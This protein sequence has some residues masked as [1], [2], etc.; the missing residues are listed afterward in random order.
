MK[1]SDRQNQILELIQTGACSSVKELCSVIYASPATIRRD[2]HAM[3]EEGLIRLLYGNIIPLTE[4]PTELPL[5]FRESQAKESRRL[6]AR[7]AAE[8][9][10]PGS[11]VLLDGSAS[12]AYM[13]DH[14]SP[15]LGITV[16]TNCIKT[17][18]KLS[19]NGVTVYLLGGKI[20][21]RGHVTSGVWTEESI[22]SIHVDYLFFSAHSLAENGMIS[23]TSESGIQLRR[24]MLRRAK[25]SYFLC[26]YEKVR[27]TSTFH[28]CD[29]RDVT[30][31]ITDADL[32]FLPDVCCI[33]V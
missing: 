26:N 31:V 11:T 7:R 8:M 13:A 17:A 5:A 22:R 29:A 3:E 24:Q 18:M 19:E 27:T 9:I 2:L 32:S 12:A 15:D 4:K 25:H 23:G 33:R 28:L 6:I 30:G 20:N 1:R 21:Y 14:I 16:F 10:P